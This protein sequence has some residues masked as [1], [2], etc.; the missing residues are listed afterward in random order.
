M[1]KPRILIQLDTDPQ[2]S[3]FDSV[4]AVDS[5]VDQLFRHGGV[6]AD[7]VR[8]L[9]YGA[10]FTRGPE[11]L[12]NTAIFVGGSDVQEAETV[13]KAVTECFFGPVRVSVML[14]ASGANSTAAAAVLAVKRHLPLAES[15][16][17]VLAATG[18]VGRRIVRLLARQGAE[19]AVTSR[20]QERAGECCL[21]IQ[22]QV[23][24]AR[25][26]PY[27]IV[28]PDGRAKS[29]E[30]SDAVIAAGAPGV[31]LLPLEDRNQCDQ[32]KVAL[33]LSAVPPAGIEGIDPQHK[34]D[35]QNGVICYGAIGVGGSKMK[36]H[37]AAI[38]RLFQSN[39]AV[40]DAEEIFAIGQ[41]L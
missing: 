40:L 7:G 32:L 16:V 4:V 10:M 12:R 9:V 6:T 20:T 17:T 13:I 2:P 31:P 21:D 3:V 14:D 36:I 41:E 5:Q 30:G 18:P 39:D 38:E 34:A 19:V 22:S 25:L 29:L 37:K 24:G 26:T 23:E 28:S 8:D 11:D 33:D 35:D 15:R 1:S 27:A